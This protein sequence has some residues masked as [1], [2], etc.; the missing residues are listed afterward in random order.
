MN[1][2]EYRSVRVERVPPG[3]SRRYHPGGRARDFPRTRLDA[4][5]REVFLTPTAIGA[6]PFSL[7]TK[8]RHGG[9][10]PISVADRFSSTCGAETV[11]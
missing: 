8:P 11:V 6:S 10:V 3:V 7:E 5:V 9:G 4:G 1:D 2:P